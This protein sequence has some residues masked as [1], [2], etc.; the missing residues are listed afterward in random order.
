MEKFNPKNERI[1][2]RYRIFLARVKKKD[3]KTW[4]AIMKHLKDFETFINFAGFESL[5]ETIIN[6]YIEHLLN[7]DLSLSHVDHN[8]KALKAFYTWLERQKGYKSK[9]DYNILEFFNLSA[10]QRKQARATEYK[11]SYEIEEIYSA[12][13]NM[14]DKTIFDRRNKAI[15]SLQALCGLRVSELRTIRI[16]NLIY[17]K[18]SQNWM[19]YVNPKDMDVKF[20]KIRHAFFMPFDND[21]KT[22]VLNWKEELEKLGFSDKDPLFPAIP[23]QFNQLNLLNS[24]LQKEFIKS[25]TT[26]R[27]VFKRAFL[28]VN[29]KYIRPHNFRH[30]IVRWAETQ[31]PQFFNA[32]SQSLGHSDIKTTFQAYGSLTPAAI[33]VIMKNTNNDLF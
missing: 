8:I 10:N 3:E 22:I 30:T 15:I 32:V 11:E 25:N 1:K 13:R 27:E 4:F 20:A 12:I 24:K 33:G 23:S 16:K 6:N 14:P 17:D 9:I 21:I 29:L 26:I 5:N 7:K 31:S 2:Y 19:I 28:A 18:Q